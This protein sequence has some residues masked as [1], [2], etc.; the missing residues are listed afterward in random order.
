MLG[1]SKQCSLVD[2]VQDLL[3][4]LFRA[5]ARPRLRG[6]RPVESQMVL[7]GNG[8]DLL[9][10]DAFAL[11]TN[12]RPV[13]FEV[14]D[15]PN[16]ISSSGLALLFSEYLLPVMLQRQTTLNRSGGSCLLQPP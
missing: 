9:G 13:A 4:V 3:G 5:R 11:L 10:C 2:L 6:K 8:I 7:V 16:Q 15:V 1:L 12:S 14:A